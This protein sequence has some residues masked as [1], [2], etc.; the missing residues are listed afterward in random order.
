MT[1]AIPANANVPEGSQFLL[2]VE[3]DL[4]EDSGIAAGDWVVV[5]SQPNASDGDIVAVCSGG[6]AVVMPFDQV[7]DTAIHLGV[8]VGVLRR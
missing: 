6:N 3:D 2:R 8:V 1:D 4:P 7:D 5:R